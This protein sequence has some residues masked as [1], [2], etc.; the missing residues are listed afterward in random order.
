MSTETSQT[1]P[2]PKPTTAAAQ[3]VAIVEVAEGTRLACAVPRELAIHEGDQCVMEH[4]RILEFG[5]VVKLL[6]PEERKDRWRPVGV[7]LRCATLQDQ[8]RAKESAVM[9][10]MARETVKAKVRK[11]GMPLRIVRVRFSF[12]RAVLMILF[13]SDERLDLKDL[14]GE[15]AGELRTRVDIKQIGVRDEAALLGGIGPCGRELCCCSWLRRF[16]PVNVRMAKT[17]GIAPN[18]GAISGM[19]GRLKCC[20]RYEFDQYRDLERLVPREGTTVECPAGRGLVI[21]RNPLAQRV[22]VRLDVDHVVEYDAN[23]VKKVWTGDRRK[24][25]EKDERKAEETG[26]E[27]PGAQWAEP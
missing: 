25:D 27:D 7:V 3:R 1:I 26:D 16:D 14:V 19:C 24:T 21:S 20:L 8:A 15:L 9:G 11:R 23:E 2:E 4:D 18:P 5:R 22:K 12:D 6:A 10:R 17:Q 13:T